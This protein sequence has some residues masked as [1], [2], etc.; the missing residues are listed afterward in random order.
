MTPIQLSSETLD[1]LAVITV[2]G[3]VDVYTGP[4][5]RE[6]LKTFTEEGAD[7]VSLVIDLDA[8]TFLDSTGVG[9][10]VG[11]MRAQEARGGRF[12]I[13]C[14]AEPVLRVLRTMGLLGRMGVCGSA[15]EARDAQVPQ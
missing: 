9:V 7:P 15:D 2:S 13:V 1:D 14:S 12:A 3:S 5:L 4:R 6:M 8:V 10:L 11:A